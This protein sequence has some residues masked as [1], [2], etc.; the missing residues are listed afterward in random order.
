MKISCLIKGLFPLIIK[1]KVKIYLGVPSLKHTLLNL[2]SLGWQPTSVVDCGA[3]EGYW[4]KEFLSVFPKT[5]MLLIEAQ[6]A[7]IGKIKQNISKNIQVC[8]ALLGATNDDEVFFSI[9]ET[10]SSVVE[11]SDN[12]FKFTT[13]MLDS[14]ISD[15]NF[16]S[17]NFIKLD[18]QGY[19]IEVLKGAKFAL[20]T[21]EFVFVEMTLMP[22]NREPII[23]EVMNYM[24]AIGF[25]L[26][27]I[28]A[29]MRK[30]YDKALYQ[31]DGLFVKK[32]SKFINSNW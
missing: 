7:K 28:S 6:K 2:K 31:I 1:K 20:Q 18:V 26:Y 11:D 23:L 13:T 27:D 25:Q 10:A 29:L 15:M 17:P 30:P 4:T 21:S 9:N 8:C 12:A 32:D 22:L 14:V 19:E 24:D 16:L 5:K 3:Y